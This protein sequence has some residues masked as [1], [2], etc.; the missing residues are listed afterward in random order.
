MIKNKKGFSLVELIVII[1]V[2]VV[3]IAVLAPSLLSYTERSRAQKDESS[4]DEVVNAVQLAMANSDVYDEAIKYSCNNNFITYTDSSGKYGQQIN[5]GEYWAPDGSG[6]ATTITFN[7]ETDSSG[8]T[9]YKLENGIVNDM[10][11][12]N[13]SV[14]QDRVMEGAQIENNQCYLKNMTQL[15]NLVRQSIGNDVITA[16]STYK[17]SS[18]T[19]FIK[20]SQ[21]D[22][23]KVADVN[24]AFNGTNLNNESQASKGS[25]TLTYDQNTGEAKPTV[26]TPGK[27]EATFT[28]SALS[29]VGVLTGNVQDYKESESYENLSKDYSFEYYSSLYLAV[30]D[31]NNGSIGRSSDSNESNAIVGVYVDRQQHPTAMLL[32]DT[33]E[34]RRVITNVDLTVC[35]NGHSLQATDVVALQNNGGH[36]IINGNKN[37]STVAM[38][39]N[40]KDTMRYLIQSMDEIT[41]NGGHYNITV[42]NGI[43]YAAVL[44]ANA[45]A[46]VNNASLMCVYKTNNTTNTGEILT[47]ISQNCDSLKI[48]NCQITLDSALSASATYGVLISKNTSNSECQNCVINVTGLVKNVYGII[49][50]RPIEIIESEVC[51]KNNGSGSVQNIRLLY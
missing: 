9:I 23:V 39:V 11:Y 49:A 18:F 25:G 45:N 47:V 46:N 21:K 13:G 51:A 36:L 41:I 33:I 40:E 28:N 17:N 1:A 26:T 37:G 27:I 15:Y 44:S 38:T 32:Q 43:S 30:Q 16:S 22:S 31:I 5:D 14:A 7:P 24:G 20:F 6:K 12:G 35:L 42:N 19:I 4:M 3:L 2:M 34:T 10:T 48:K 50:W 29:G 8:K